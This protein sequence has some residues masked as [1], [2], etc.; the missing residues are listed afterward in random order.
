MILNFRNKLLIA[1][2]G[3]IALSCLLLAVVSVKG[4]TQE[5]ENSLQH[6]IQVT[7]TEATQIISTW[8]Q[9]KYRVLNAA[10]DQLTQDVSALPTQLTLAKN[11]GGFDLF[12]LGTQ[13]GKMLQSYPPVQLKPDYDP[14][15]RPWYQQAQAQQ[16]PI[17]TAPYPRASTGEAVVTFAVPMQTVDRQQGV[18]AADITLTEIIESL[19]QLDSR[20]QSE[21]WLTDAQGK[22]IAHP[23]KSLINRD[24]TSLITK[25]SQDHKSQQVHYQGASW[26][27]TQQKIKHLDWQL[28][29]LVNKQE[30][31]QAVY[32]LKTQLVLL[33]S[34]IVLGAIAATFLVANYFSRPLVEITQAL[35]TLAEGNVNQYI[36]L[37]TKDEFGKIAQAFN[38]LVKK[39]DNTLGHTHQ[40]TAQLLADIERNAQHSQNTQELIEHQ[41]NELVQLNDALAQMTEAT[42]NIATN[43]E[44]T[45]EV[46]KRSVCA[47]QE[48]VGLVHQSRKALDQLIYDVKHSAQHLSNLEKSVVEIRGILASISEISE[49]TNLLALNAAIEA[50]RAGEAGRGFAVVADEVRSLSQKTQNATQEI[51]NLI[52]ILEKVTQQTLLTMRQSEQKADA[53]REQ[54]EAVHQQLIHIDQENSG[55]RDLAH[56][57][58]VA[59]AQ[60]RSMSKEMMYHAESVRGASEILMQSS[61]EHHQETLQLKLEIDAL[62]KHL[63]Q[64]FKLS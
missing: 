47:G 62:Q 63:H 21:L 3:L 20:W 10:K 53:S 8:T 15:K 9:D 56:Q 4:L 44:T 42:A 23:D 22:L 54:S 52:Q 51:H 58:S 37:N 27:L 5:T 28:I 40:L 46:S 36:Q 50:A 55:V 30:A 57:T 39:L 18:L 7:L 1:I 59:V 17:V 11:A 32:S 31:T 14:R 26:F 41:K 60:Q 45:L 38:Y 48:G 6:Q 2:V 16:K 24:Y 35:H 33:C 29:L 19:L 43:A 25:T 64:A 34:L 12:Y 49:Q 13:T 61:T